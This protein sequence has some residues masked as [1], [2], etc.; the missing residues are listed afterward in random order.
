M[1]QIKITICLV[2]IP[3]VKNVYLFE[4]FYFQPPYSG[5]QK[6]LEKMFFRLITI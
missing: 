4:I 5:Y 2:T 1:K 3:L 6:L